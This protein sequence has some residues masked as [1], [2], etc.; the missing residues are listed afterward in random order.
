MG[1][2]D[3]RIPIKMEVDSSDLQNL[4]SEVEKTF[5]EIHEYE[6]K[7]STKKDPWNVKDVSSYESQVNSLLDKMKQLQGEFDTWSKKTPFEDLKRV[8]SDIGTQIKLNAQAQKDI[9]SE[10]MRSLSYL[11]EQQK[12]EE[13]VRRID[14]EQLALRR[15]YNKA[16]KSVD[17]ES[18]GAKSQL[19]ELEKQYNL[20]KQ[21]LEAD[22]MSAQSRVNIN[23]KFSEEAAERERIARQNYSD[24][25][26]TVSDLREQASSLGKVA[27][28]EGYVQQFEEQRRSVLE[29]INRQLREMEELI[30]NIQYKS[31]GNM[32]Q[33]I[34]DTGYQTPREKAVSKVQEQS[35][36]E[37]ARQAAEMAKIEKQLEA[38]RAKT[39]RDVQ[40][41][42]RDAERAVAKAHRDAEAATRAQNRALKEEVSAIKQTASQY[43][44]KLRSIKML[45]FVVSQANKNLDN[46]GKKTTQFATKA[47]SAY[48]KLIPG[49]N[50]LKKALDK[51]STSQKKLNREVKSTTNSHEGFN[52]SLKKGLMTILK[53]GLGIRSL[54]VLINKLRKA[55]T[56][57]IGEMSKQF[58]D[59]NSKMSI[60]LTEI[61]YMKASLTAMVQPIINLL[62]PA[63][64]KLSAVVAKISYQVSSF[65]AL[66]TGQDYVYKAI[67]VQADY[68]ASL[69]KTGKSAKKARKELAGFDELNVL[70]SDSDDDDTSGLGWEIVPAMEQAAG[71]IDKIKG[72]LSKLLE[73]LKNAWENM[74]DFVLS[75]WN[76]MV[77]KLKS[78]LGT[79]W[80]DFLKVWTDGRVQKIFEDILRIVGDIFLIIGN[81]AEAIEEAWKYNDNGY[82]SLSAIVDSIG[83]IVTGLKECADYTVLWSEKLSFVP[84][85]S[86]IADI[87]EQQVVPAVQKV[88]DLFVY[89]YENVFLE[90]ARFI[91]EELAPIF[92]KVVGNIVEAI[93]N[94]AEN[95]RTA[96]EEN[97]RGAQILQQIEKL[98]TI[99]A[100]GILDA[101]EKTK[102]WAKN[103]DFANLVESILTFLEKIEPVVQFIT[104]VTNKLWTDVVLPFWKYMIEEGGPKL[105]DILGQIIDKVDWDALKQ[106][107]DT[108]LE[109]LE[110]FLELTWETILQIIKDLGEAFADFLNSETLGK[111]VDGFKDWVENADPE[112]LAHK[113]E[114]FTGVMIGLKGVLGLF[115]KVIFPII[116]AYM[117]VKNAIAQRVMISAVKN[118]TKALGGGAAGGG[119]ASAAGSGGLVGSLG[120]VALVL[121][122]IGGAI[123]VVG[124]GMETFRLGKL[125]KLKND[126]PETAS[127]TN[128][129]VEE[130][131]G[132]ERIFK[133]VYETFHPGETLADHIVVPSDYEKL[134]TMKDK[135]IDMSQQMENA[136]TLSTDT[137][138][139]ITEALDIWLSHGERMED[140]S[141]EEVQHFSALYKS[142]EDYYNKVSD[143][144][145]AEDAIARMSADWEKIPESVP[146][147]DAGSLDGKDY[148][149]GV[150]DG[151]H[152][153]DWE[154]VSELEPTKGIVPDNNAALTEGKEYADGIID[155]IQT[156]DWEKISETLPSSED[157]EASGIALAE[158][159]TTAVNTTIQNSVSDMEENGKYLVQGLDSGVNQQL[160]ETDTTSWWQKILQSIKDFF[161]IGSPSVVMQEQGKFI[162]QGLLLGI[163]NMV[164]SIINAVSNFSV[165]IFTSFS[166]MWNSLKTNTQTAWSTFTS[167]I[168]T[169]INS[170]L[171]DIKKKINAKTLS[172]S[173]KEFITGLKESAMEVWK[174]LSVKLESGIENILSMF[175]QRLNSNTLVD[176][177]R[178]LIDGLASGLISKLKSVLEQVKSI[179]REVVETARSA[180]KIH[181][182]S[183]VFAEIGENLMQGM[184]DGIENTADVTYDTL[185]NVYGNL[186]QQSDK[187]VKQVATNAYNGELSTVSKRIKEVVSQ[188]KVYDDEF[189]KQLAKRMEAQQ[190]W[191]L[192]LN[193]AFTSR[194]LAD[195]YRN[196]SIQAT[197]QEFARWTVKELKDLYKDYWNE[198]SGTSQQFDEIIREL[199]QIAP[200][201]ADTLSSTSANDIKHSQ[202]YEALTKE[203]ESLTAAQNK[204]FAK[205]IPSIATGSVL[206]S[207]SAFSYTTAQNLNADLVKNLKSALI[208]SFDSMRYNGTE[209]Q[210]IVVQI[211]GYEVFRAVRNQSDI[212]RNA[213]GYGVL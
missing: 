38:E 23:K 207:S 95:I 43:Y 12:A 122:D 198:F 129:V 28:Q 72:M 157:G 213:T 67:K 54:Y 2:E 196:N 105:L 68:A 189:D 177:G 161:H 47:L 186:I 205:N 84:L 201:I 57:G 66:L 171:A 127:A 19:R 63:F 5:K 117:T 185:H 35:R 77:K 34:K 188:L 118:L 39:V 141:D 152:T 167:L 32:Q 80:D 200:D 135:L 154:R 6:S 25:Q 41:E 53:Y 106:K 17:P 60:I 7:R 176:V 45:G 42:E 9:S 75:S 156:A 97:D 173:G 29:G 94:I 61:N 202:E 170:L 163:Q 1:E 56:D 195:D 137:G 26:R 164:P 183:K 93:G 134:E 85:F 27:K 33:D 49:V 78:L 166:N 92:V 151:I 24:G 208:E 50:A 119:A 133:K 131:N 114:V 14:K 146:T 126:L 13:E 165:Q 192:A 148:A 187:L 65:V 62:A 182:P 8:Q 193:N 86:A 87:L 169:N 59:V 155:G 128:G 21:Q 211:D 180:F 124:A 74:R 153:A 190:K 109:A 136:G 107:V 138:N 89:L 73:P 76:T 69:D 140:L 147:K 160:A 55:I 144:K 52:I 31:R 116:T 11:R 179:C 46:F 16:V 81:I 108:F 168:T 121:A 71:W 70:H 83:I 199:K 112:D 40:K 91:V 30:T 3:V 174:E 139:K 120:A 37:E 142:V 96:L 149:D 111:I 132:L 150:I 36:K 10:H 101:S 209:N 99:V 15:Q 181:S 212:F 172:K 64:E 58:D 130:L 44:Y 206:P 18:K 104:D 102:E 191:N 90:I 79:I 158:G 22:K 88:V 143:S 125:H 178:N 210:D 162:M 194:G 82:R 20:Q 175:K 51:T 113:I 103:L 123:A 100:N 4:K 184:A 110:P 98:V 197:P 145:A 159:V 115:A 204:S 48:L 203:L